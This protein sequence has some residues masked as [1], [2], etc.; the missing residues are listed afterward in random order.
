MSIGYKLRRLRKLKGYTQKQLGLMVGFSEESADVR[1]TQYETGTRV[2]KEDVV[3]KMAE[4]LG[5]NPNYLMAPVPADPE[6][7]MR[8]LFFLD[9]CSNIDLTAQEVINYEGF[10]E[11][12]INMSFRGMDYFLNKWYEKQKELKKGLISQEEYL[13]WKINWEID[14]NDI[15]DRENALEY[16]SEFGYL[17][18]SKIYNRL[19]ENFE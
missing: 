15:N 17:I 13:D 19:N 11:K 8:V 12:R 18:N 2:P 1:I 9:D 16:L 10:E 6:E 5:A 3:K 7:I 4:I 14:K